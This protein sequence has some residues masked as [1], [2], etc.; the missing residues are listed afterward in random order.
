MTPKINYI[1]LWLHQTTFKNQRKPYSFYKVLIFEISRS[2]K[3]LLFHSYFRKDACRKSWRSVHCFLKISN[4]G[5]TSSRKTTWVVLYELIKQLH[6][7]FYFQLKE[8]E[9]FDFI[10]VS[11]EGIAPPRPFGFPT[12]QQPLSWGTRVVGTK[13]GLVVELNT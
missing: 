3:S 7:H 9:H 8:L 6:F 10:L 5:A 1:W 4:M 11:I 12:L 13:P 2:C